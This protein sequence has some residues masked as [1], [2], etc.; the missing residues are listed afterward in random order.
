[1]SQDGTV[2]EATAPPALESLSSSEL[3][4]WRQTG[5]QFPSTPE[6]PSTPTAESSP[7]APDAQAVS[8]DTQPPAASEP[9]TPKKANAETRKA[10]LKAEIETLARQRADLQR[11][12]ESLSQSRARPAAPPD[13]P[14]V[15]SSSTTQPKT[16]DAILASPDPTVPMLSEK[17]FFE[18]YADATV[19]D[20]SRYVARYEI[21]R[22][23]MQSDRD[24]AKASRDTAFKQALSE[25]EKA[26][27]DYWVK[28]KPVAVHLVPLDGL[29]AGK[30]PQPLNYAAQEILESPIGPAILAHLA[31]HPETM[32][33]LA[34]SDPRQ[35]IK[36]IAR[37]EERLAKP[38]SVAPVVKTTSSAPPP[39]V[40]LGSKASMPSDDVDSAVQTGDFQR[41]KA[42]MNR[43]EAAL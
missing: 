28:V 20:L 16:L 26:D 2:A 18:T 31:A 19:A 23:R 29:P 7:A 34:A 22:A 17:E 37:L 30:T 12:I 41:Y 21:A 25:A 36:T 27:P 10:E 24:T 38:V 32:H 42:T 39:P 6:T 14:P 13:A 15:D 35:A 4:S 11:E 5:H 43:R 40:T 3:A 8:T 9:A 1:M 33:E